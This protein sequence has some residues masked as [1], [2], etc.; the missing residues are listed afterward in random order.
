VSAF[1]QTAAPL[2][3]AETVS[4][5]FAARA[6]E[7][8]GA[9]AACAGERSWTYGELAHRAS[10]IGRALAAR[11]AR[12]GARV[13]VVLDPSIDLLAGLVNYLAFL[14]RAYQVGERDR[15]LF[16]TSYAFDASI[17]EMFWPLAYGARVAIAAGD[18]RTDPAA[19]AELVHAHGATV[20]QGVPLLLAAVA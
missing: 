15:V 13:A 5:L 8:P 9:I 17:V 18:Q 20:L 2:P 7:A 19:I 11:G 10:A 4:H 14:Q 6:A 1:N 16:T 12:R 3:D